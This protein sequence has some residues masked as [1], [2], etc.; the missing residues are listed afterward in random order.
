MIRNGV[1]ANLVIGIIHIL[2]AFLGLRRSHELHASMLP[3]GDVFS[4]VRARK[5]SQHMNNVCR[6]TS[7]TCFN[8]QEAMV[9]E[10]IE[11]WTRSAAV[12]WTRF[13]IWVVVGD[14]ALRHRGIQRLANK[15]ETYGG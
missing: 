6:I 15:M 8:S 10:S 4:V 3:N 9:G 11:S 1:L 13:D 2:D 12:R 14:W 5:E 7:G